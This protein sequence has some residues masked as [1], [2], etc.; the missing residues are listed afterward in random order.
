VTTT[1]AAR[2]D[3]PSVLIVGAVVW[4]TSEL[5]FFGTLFGSYFTLRSQADGP[6][7]P[8]GAEVS[9][10]IAALGTALLVTSSATVQLAARAAAAHRTREVQRWLV[11]TVVLGAVFLGLQVREWT[12]LPFSAGD[13]PYGTIF[14]TMTGFHGLHVLGGLAAM[15]VLTWRST[16]RQVRHDAI[17]VMSFY[18]H[19]VDVVW[20]AL[21]AT[22]Y[23]AS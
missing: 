13:H 8:E 14:Y 22:V 9:R 2:R 20:L 23:L 11:V 19:F 6:W 15:L 12:V 10:A 7:P 18:W 5:L 16:Q 1:A 4:I 3:P 21:F 17:E